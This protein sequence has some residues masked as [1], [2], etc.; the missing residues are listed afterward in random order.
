MN[1]NQADNTLHKL[2]S[3]NWEIK[4]K[5]DQIKGARIFNRLTRFDNKFDIPKLNLELKELE[6]EYNRAKR[7]L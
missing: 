4:N 3:L 1:Y 2:M 6:L 5:G 7:E